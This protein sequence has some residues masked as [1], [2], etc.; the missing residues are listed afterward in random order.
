MTKDRP[1][2]DALAFMQQARAKDNIEYKWVYDYG[3]DLWEYEN[4]HFESFNERADSIIKYLGTGTGLLALGLLAKADHTNVHILW[5]SIPSLICAL[6]AIGLAACSK[7][8]FDVPSIPAVK[9]AKEYAD[10]YATERESI[11]AFVGQ[12]HLACEKMKLASDKKADAFDLSLKL[13]IW[14]VVLLL[15]PV[16]AALISPPHP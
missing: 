16:F 3:K 9:Q 15:L 12:W 13:Y 5:W 11:A 10:G 14:A 6:V 8:P 2:L 7:R 1:C 4:S